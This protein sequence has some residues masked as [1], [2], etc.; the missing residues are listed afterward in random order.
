MVT[1]QRGWRN[2]WWAGCF[3]KGKKGK[4]IKRGSIISS[5]VR[6]VP[7]HQFKSG[8]ADWL[9]ILISFFCFFPFMKQISQWLGL[10][11]LTLLTRQIV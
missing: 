11:I 9:N 2:H 5:T 3:I 6:R 7:A 1:Y 4:K 8:F 10:K